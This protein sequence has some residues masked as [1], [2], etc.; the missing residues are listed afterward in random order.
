MVGVV[1]EW[2]ERGLSG[3][4]VLPMRVDLSSF[5]RPSSWKEREDQQ[6][7][8]CKH[9]LVGK[10]TSLIYKEVEILILHRCVGICMYIY[11]YIY[12]HIDGGS[13]KDQER[14]E[15]SKRGRDAAAE[16]SVVSVETF[17]LNFAKS[18]LYHLKRFPF[19]IV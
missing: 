3:R 12:I 8:G 13:R 10:K 9:L 4:G 2:E 14:R 7:K 16:L 17:W 19:P 1:V 18:V 15:E 11:V 6:E 5:S